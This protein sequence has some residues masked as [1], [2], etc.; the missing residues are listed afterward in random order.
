MHSGDIGAHE[1]GFSA[2]FGVGSLREYGQIAC[3]PLP[4]GDTSESE[5]AECSVTVDMLLIRGAFDAR[6]GT[7]HQ[8]RRY[9]A[10]CRR[11]RRIRRDRIRTI[12]RYRSCAEF[13]GIR[14]AT[15]GLPSAGAY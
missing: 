15:H 10:V 2:V 9:A 12:D 8:E 14:Q 1:V 3:G 13:D 6:P 5:S 7:F 11:N 4:V